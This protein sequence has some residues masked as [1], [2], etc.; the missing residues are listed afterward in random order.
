MS[1]AASTPSVNYAAVHKPLW[2]TP[3]P[4][5]LYHLHCYSCTTDGFQFYM[6]YNFDKWFQHK[7][8]G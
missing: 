2:C 4:V 8:S 3:N 5:Q 1:S 7:V 6:P